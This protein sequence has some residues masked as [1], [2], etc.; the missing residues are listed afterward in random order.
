MIFGHS[1][2]GDPS[3][4]VACSFDTRIGAKGDPDT[5]VRSAT[6]MNVP[7]LAAGFLSDVKAEVY[8]VT[9]ASMRTCYIVRPASET[10]PAPPHLVAADLAATAALLELPSA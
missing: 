6:G 7:T 4:L 9:T 2:D 10:E 3:G 8:A 1:V 5:R